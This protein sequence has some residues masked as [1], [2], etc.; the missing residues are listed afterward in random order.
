MANLKKPT[1]NQKEIMKEHGLKWE[2]WLVPCRG[3]D[4]NTLVVINRES[5]RKRVLLK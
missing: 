5:G 3:E 2:N 4:N 1:R